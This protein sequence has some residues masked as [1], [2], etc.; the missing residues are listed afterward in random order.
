VGALWARTVA[1]MSTLLNS[2]AQSPNQT[3]ICVNRD[4]FAVIVISYL[5]TTVYRMRFYNYSSIKKVNIKKVMA[6]FILLRAFLQSS[7]LRTL[8][9]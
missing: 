6:G 5:L 1:G 2:K 3:D 4:V 8:S 7:V 9:V